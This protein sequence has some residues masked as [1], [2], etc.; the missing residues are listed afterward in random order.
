MTEDDIH[1]FPGDRTPASTPPAQALRRSL[2]PRVRP[3]LFMPMPMRRRRSRAAAT[4]RQ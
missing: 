2:R 3:G 1:A 4:M